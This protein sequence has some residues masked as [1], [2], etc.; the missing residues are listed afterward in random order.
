MTNLISYRINLSNIHS[1]LADYMNYHDE[2]HFF[3]I[4]IIIIVVGKKEQHIALRD[5]MD[6]SNFNPKKEKEKC[7][8]YDIN[9]IKTYN[10]LTIRQF[11]KGYVEHAKIHFDNKELKYCLFW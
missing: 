5:N 3:G 7:R 1:P 2:F 10:R 9:N 11:T 4:L 8:C 6:E